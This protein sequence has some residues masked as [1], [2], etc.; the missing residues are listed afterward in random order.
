M[1]SSLGVRVSLSDTCNSPSLFSAN[2]SFVAEL[3]CGFIS[4]LLSSSKKLSSL[5]SLA[6]FLCASY[7]KDT[8]SSLVSAVNSGKL[9]FASGLENSVLGPLEPSLKSV[10]ISSS[11]NKPYSSCVSSLLSSCSSFDASFSIVLYPLTPLLP[12]TS[13]SFST[14]CVMSP[15][16]LA[17]VSRSALADISSSNDPTPSSLSSFSSSSG[18][19]LKSSDVLSSN[20]SQAVTISGL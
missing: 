4:S 11:I 17:V 8:P 9:S 10:V 1:F 7:C 20:A 16:R 15:S 13:T 14:I 19:L 6:S 18:S 3:R 5:P 2:S 12:A